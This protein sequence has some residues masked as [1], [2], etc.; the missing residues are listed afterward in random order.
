[1]QA[2]SAQL[3]QSF[4]DCLQ[5]QLAGT[6]E[7]ASAAVTAQSGPV[8]GHSLAWGALARRVKGFLRRIAG[9]T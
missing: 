2:V 1:V 9:R 6:Q 7:E 3:V 4:A 8:K 5:A